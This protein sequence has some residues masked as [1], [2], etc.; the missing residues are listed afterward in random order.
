MALTIQEKLQQKQHYALVPVHMISSVIKFLIIEIY[1][2][3]IR[4]TILVDHEKTQL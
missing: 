2:S 3:E 4:R 1:A